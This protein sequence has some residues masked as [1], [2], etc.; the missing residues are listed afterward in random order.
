V[1][2]DRWLAGALEDEEE[3]ARAAAAEKTAG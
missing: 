3:K 1:V 2:M